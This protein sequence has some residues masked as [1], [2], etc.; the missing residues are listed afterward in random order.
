[1]FIA[2]AIVLVLPATVKAQEASVHQLT[3]TLDQGFV[4]RSVSLDVFGGKLNVSW[5]KGTLIA[6]SDLT[7]KLVTGA[8]TTIEQAIAASG[9]SIQFAKAEAI[10]PQ[11]TFRI[12]MKADRPPSSTEQGEASVVTGAA[13]TTIAQ[14][15]FVK[16]RLSFRVPASASVVVLP[17]YRDGIMRKGMAS[18]YAYKKCLC[19]AS[20]DVPKGTRLIVRRADNPSRFTVV[21]VNDW[22]PERDKHPE[23]VIDLDKVAFSRIGNPRGGVMA[24]TVDVVS[25]EDPLW[26]LGD[27]LPPPNW[28][29][30]IAAL[31]AAAVSK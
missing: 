24:V 11:G 29:K 22:G 28:K 4:D 9:I 7:I 25:P 14:G 15:T 18:W 21:T 17:A 2:V 19:A 13:S 8:T 26:K 31:R 16:D 20:P 12:T 5:D 30:L 23:R 1:M 6:P 10:H 27:E 3:L